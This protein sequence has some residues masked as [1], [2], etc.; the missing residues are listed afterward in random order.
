MPLPSPDG[1]AV[2]L[3]IADGGQRP[4][5]VVMTAALRHLGVDVDSDPRLSA[6]TEAPVLGH[7]QTRRCRKGVGTARG[8]RLVA[9]GA[10]RPALPPDAVG[11]P[12]ADSLNASP[13]PR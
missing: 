9:E 10:V 4:R 1:S 3:K 12:T 7:G 8:H 6:L 5:P 11:S 2:A 13:L